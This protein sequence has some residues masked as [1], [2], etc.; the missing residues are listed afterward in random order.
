[1]ALSSLALSGH[2][3]LSSSRISP[4]SHSAIVLT[5]LLGTAG[6]FSSIVTKFD[7]ASLPNIVLVVTGVVVVDVLSQYAPQTG[8]IRALQTA[9]Y[10]FLYLAIT[11]VCGVLAA[12]AMQRFAFPLRDQLFANADSALGLHWPDFAHWVD[13][14]PTV[15]ALLR[16]AYDSILL[17]T[18]LPLIVFALTSRIADLRVYLLAFAVAFT[19]TIIISM[20]LPAAGPIIFVDRADFS[21]LHFTGA[22]P[23]E[24]LVRLRASGPLI[25]ND[26]PGGIATFPSFH[27][28]I[29]TLTPLTLRGFPL[30]FPLLLI[31]DAAMLAGTVTEGAHYFIDVVAGIGMA[32]FGHFAAK[33]II[34]T[35]DRFASAR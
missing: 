13:R 27:A 26:A 5:F 15:Q 23:I 18:A 16:P 34:A 32:F 3:A 2:R 9:L 4:V 12:Y 8:V 31:L 11:I 14:H 21:I 30:I 1:M 19:S 24:H 29:A 7:L 33:R 35:E 25:M 6:L 28:T 22:T 20:L 17:Q 10:G